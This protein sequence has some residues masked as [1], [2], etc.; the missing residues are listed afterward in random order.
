MTPLNVEEILVKSKDRMEHSP[1]TVFSRELCL[2][3]ESGASVVTPS[4]LSDITK[5]FG[6]PSADRSVL[7]YFSK[8]CTLLELRIWSL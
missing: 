5:E 2:G 3:G 8:G 1:D 4:M 7:Y 6:F